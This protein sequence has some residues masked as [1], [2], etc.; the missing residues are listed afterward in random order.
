MRHQFENDLLP[1]AQ[2]K[3]WPTVIPFDKVRER[4]ERMKESFLVIILDE[5]SS[6]EDFERGEAKGPRAQ[7]HFWREFMK[8]V[9]NNGSRAA[10]G[11]SGQY[12]SFQKL[13]PG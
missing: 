7:S 10:I 8:E 13:Q 2:R 1:M 6:Q 3:K 4:V 12:R 9:K 5:E 11:A